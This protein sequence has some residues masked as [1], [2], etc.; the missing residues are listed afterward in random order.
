M[1]R[2]VVPL[3]DTKIRQAKPR[4]KPYKLFD[5]GGL[6]LYI[7]PKG[8]KSWRMKY[9]HPLTGREQTITF[10]LYPDI[11]LKK[12][13]AMREK[14]REA[15]LEGRDPKSP[16]EGE[17]PKFRDLATEWLYLQ[18]IGDK[19]R[20]FQHGRLNNHINPRIGD[21]PIDRITQ[22]DVARVLTEVYATGKEETA[23]RLHSIISSVLKYGVA[24]G[25]IKHNVAADIDRATLIP[26]PTKTHMRTI[27]DPE[28]IAHF[29]RAIIEY[30]GHWVTSRAMLMQLYTATRP[31]ETRGMRWEEIDGDLWYIPAE[32]MKMKRPHT[33][34]LSSFAQN[35]IK[36]MRAYSGDSRFVFPSPLSKTRPISDNTVNTAI[37][38]IGY[39]DKIVAH[40]MRSMFSTIAHEY[41]NF[42][43]EIIEAQLV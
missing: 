23:G 3:S 37:K 32:R 38:R 20:R 19:H 8:A 30:P 42:P 7:S 33:V 1:A 26:P 14:V 25:L 24:R 6:Y 21:L 10:G 22:R 39:G 13:R 9:R 17:V 2:G 36:E 12:A 41:S 43:H 4:E 34:P 40:G 11:S 18:K 16:T 29:L 5:G 27:T 15:L 31:G 28:E 35:I